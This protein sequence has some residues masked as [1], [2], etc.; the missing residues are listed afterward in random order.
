MGIFL[1]VKGQITPY[2]V[3]LFGRNLTS[4]YVVG[5]MHVFDTYKFKM[6]HINSKR[7]KVKT[8]IF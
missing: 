1:D 3:V 4:S 5:I 8:S 7:E 6:D 2:Y